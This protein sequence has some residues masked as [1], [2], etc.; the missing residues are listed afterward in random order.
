MAQ[1]LGQRSITINNVQPRPTETDINPA[2]GASADEARQHIALD[3]YAPVDEMAD[4]VAY[5]PSPGASFITGAS[6]AFDGGYAA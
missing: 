1:T 4:F 3:R 5:L 2:S 6:L